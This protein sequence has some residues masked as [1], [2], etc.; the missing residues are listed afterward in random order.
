MYILVHIRYILF[1]LKTVIKLVNKFNNFSN[2]L[3]ITIC[4]VLQHKIYIKIH[5]KFLLIKNVL[6]SIYR[7]M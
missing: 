5:N 2:N 6:V 3:I 1:M 4:L 7:F